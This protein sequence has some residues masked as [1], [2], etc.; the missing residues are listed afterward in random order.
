MSCVMGKIAQ[1]KDML[2]YV[3]AKYR[4]VTKKRNEVCE[5]NVGMK[6]NTFGKGVACKSPQVYVYFYA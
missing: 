1:P 6:F 3:S 4:R 5:R 2:P